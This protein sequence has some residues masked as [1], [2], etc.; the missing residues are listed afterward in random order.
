MKNFIALSFL[1]L[2]VGCSTVGGVYD[3]GR[4]V[5]TGTID[6][7]ATGTSQVV[8]AVTEDVVDVIAF[9]G[10]TTA[11]MIAKTSEYIDKEPDEIQDKEEKK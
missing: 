9:T 6:T 11:G 3:A 7:V 1:I 10:D 2:M 8:S 4:T 5:V